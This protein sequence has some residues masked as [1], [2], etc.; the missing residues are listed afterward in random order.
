MFT[1]ILTAMW[2]KLFRANKKPR[3][4][5]GYIASSECERSLV[6]TAVGSSQRLKNCHLLFHWLAF[7]I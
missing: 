4:P 7:I 6:R 5:S 3:W 2:R 1:T